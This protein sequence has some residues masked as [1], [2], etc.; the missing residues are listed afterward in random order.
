MV[1]EEQDMEDGFPQSLMSHTVQKKQN[2][3]QSIFSDHLRMI[4]PEYL[5]ADYMH[6]K[7]YLIISKQYLMHPAHQHGAT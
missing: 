6:F 7:I 3:K 5:T 4:Y 2:K 1:A